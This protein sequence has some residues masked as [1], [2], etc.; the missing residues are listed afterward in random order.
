MKCHQI[1]T[2]AVN[3][4]DNTYS[5]GSVEGINF[6]VYCSGCN[7]VILSSTFEAVQ[8]IP[9]ILNGNIQVNA[10]NASTDVGKIAACYGGP[11]KSN[12]LAPISNTISNRIII[13]E[14]TSIEKQISDHKLDYRWIKT[15][16]IEPNCSVS[17]L[18][19]NTE[20]N[21][22]LVGGVQIQLWQLSSNVNENNKTISD[23]RKMN[24]K[25]SDWTLVWSCQTSTP[26][27]HLSFSP[28]GTLFCSTGRADCLV[29]IWYQVS[30]QN[31]PSSLFDNASMAIGH[32]KSYRSDLTFSFIYI[33][34]PR[35]V[36]G[37]SWRK[38]SKYMPKGSVANMLVTSCRDNICRLWVQTFLP[39]DDM[40]NVTQLENVSEMITPRAQTQ[41]H[42]QRILQFFRHKKF[43]RRQ[44]STDENV[45]SNMN[46]SDM[47]PIQNL[48]S[49][50]SCHDFHG[51]GV[52]G[53]A[54][55]PAGLHFH[56]TT[57]INAENGIPLVPSLT[58][59]LADSTHSNIGPKVTVN[60]DFEAQNQQASSCSIPHQ[61][62][63]HHHHHEESDKPLFVVNW[64]NNKEKTFTQN[65][66]Q[67]LKEI[68]A[69]IN[70]G[71]RQ[72]Q[73]QQ[74]QQQQHS[75]QDEMSEISNIISD[76]TVE[77]TRKIR[78]GHEP[79]SAQPVFSSRNSSSNVSIVTAIGQDQ[80]GQDNSDPE[81]SHLTVADY[82]D[83]R[84][85]SLVRD[86]NQT[87][88]LLYSIHPLDGSLL[89]WYGILF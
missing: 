25:N 23:E 61:G 28:D 60:N 71:E 24:E 36:I 32:G 6:T 75:D 86:W 13:F 79:G 76:N 14:P 35:A 38:V 3:S 17:V 72:Q 33:P 55:S 70:A 74:Q 15:A 80:P 48:P 20:G 77:S 42:R 47:Q 67:I 27:C 82:L 29:K 9:G 50:Y 31:Y 18:S 73:F 58:Q 68:V 40:V 56:L 2:G 1:L 81:R 43:T 65:F 49:T 16:E 63:H 53:M 44:K 22:L 64:L 10:I 69:N 85:E 5:T 87:S 88:D 46:I 8:I 52:H 62:S 4:G 21:K 11:I 51:Y 66:E 78:T 57:S 84:I 7:I 19:W 26:I 39:E 89:V 54:I 34:H 12:Q 41:R 30:T 37:I 83:R 45:D 59:H